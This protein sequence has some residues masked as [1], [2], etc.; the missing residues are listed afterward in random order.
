MRDNFS[1]ATIKILAA[2]VAYICSNPNCNKPTV[3]AGQEKDKAVN[4]GVAAHI[5]AAAPGGKRYNAALS[6]AERVDSSNGIWLC[7]NCSKLID[8][9]DKVYT[10]ALLQ[11]WKHSAEQKAQMA[12]IGNMHNN[13]AGRR[14]F[15]EPDLIWKTK[16]R[17]QTGI[18]PL[19]RDILI[20]NGGH[21]IHV[22]DVIRIFQ[23][24]WRYDFKVYNNSSVPLIN[25]KLSRGVDSPFFTS[26]PLI[27]KVNNIAP[28]QDITLLAEFEFTFEG[29]GQESLEVMNPIF[30]P[31]LND[32]KFLLEYQSE[33]RRIFY[34]ECT[35]N[36]GDYTLTNHIQK[37]AGF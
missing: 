31:R 9:D 22:Y 24:H 15:A 33:D 21:P 3:G 18:S 25:L 16:S 6:P 29:T 27:P 2:R 23:I 14:P 12:I 10:I 37:P 20:R 19:N 36:N 34:T 17:W 28:L 7:Q 30:S 13:P 26:L 1:A 32:M 35:F 8:S 5:T 11:D 4:I